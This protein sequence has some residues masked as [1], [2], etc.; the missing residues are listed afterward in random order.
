MPKGSGLGIAAHRSFLTYVATVV[1][2]QVD[3][4]GAISVPRV[5]TAIDCGFAVNPERIFSQVEGCAI[6][7]LTLAKYGAITLKAGRVEQSNFDNY[8][9]V[10]IDERPK[11]TNVHIVPHGIDVP[12]AGIGEPGLPP[13]AP[14]LCN[15]IFAAT[16][17]RIRSLP[18]GSQLA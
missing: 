1:E 13:F 9:L 18:I 10:R 11:V 4:K 14:A 8:P 6:M 2:V 15:A 16:G 12:A 3:D 7:G 5:D 17:K